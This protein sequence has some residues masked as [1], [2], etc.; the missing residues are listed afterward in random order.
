MGTLHDIKKG[1]RQRRRRE[2]TERV[3]RSYN[4]AEPKV[5]VTASWDD[6]KLGVTSEG[7]VVSLPVE[8]R[9]LL[10]SKG[11]EDK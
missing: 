7:R 6:P 1:T 5:P 3:L 4:I 10:E 11:A 8:F 9:E 2:E